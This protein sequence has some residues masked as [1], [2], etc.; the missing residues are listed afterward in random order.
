MKR[1]GIVYIVSLLALILITSCEEEIDL[2]LDSEAYSKLVVEGWITDN[3]DEQVIK[4]TMTA[5]YDSNKPCPPA[6]GADV[7]VYDG[8]VYYEFI[9]TEP[10]LYIASNFRGRQGVR[11]FL[12]IVHESKTY[13]AV[14]EMRKKFPI[15]SLTVEVFPF[16][17][18]ADLPHYQL[19][20]HG[21]DDPEPNQFYVF[22]YAKNGVWNDT[23]MSWSFLSD[24]AVNGKYLE[25]TPISII[26][27][28]S[29]VFEVEVRSLSVEQEYLLFIDQCF[30]SYM[31]NMFFSPP[32]ATVKGNITNGA[33][34]YFAAASVSVSKK[35]TVRRDDHFP[36]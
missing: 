31:P 5:P 1:S 14:S 33:L 11:Y 26:E 8:E 3:S 9:E 23:L 7:T 20:V 24:F 25:Q 32:P 10:G 36:G 22:Q 17:M 12:T 29:D 34:G 4:L 19:Y 27:T 18:P 16:G 30:Y 6:I 2:N 35:I 13:E 28:Y 15:D 21:Q